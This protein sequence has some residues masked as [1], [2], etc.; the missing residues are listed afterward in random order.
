MLSM[1]LEFSVVKMNSSLIY[2]LPIVMHLTDANLQ[3][4]WILHH[5]HVA[6]S[7]NPS[8]CRPISFVVALYLKRCHYNQ[9]MPGSDT[10]KHMFNVQN[11]PK[12]KF[13]YHSFLGFYITPSDTKE[14]VWFLPIQILM[15]YFYAPI[16]S[17]SA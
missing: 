4:S 5:P 10:V 8:G 16:H 13:F 7:T 12:T 1:L 9:T 15:R 14:Y 17:T 3:T 2:R 11:R 6:V